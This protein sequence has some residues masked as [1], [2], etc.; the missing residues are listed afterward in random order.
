MEVDTIPERLT[1]SLT[2]GDLM[3]SPEVVDRIL[4]LTEQGWGRRRIAK[5]LGI[6]PKTVLRYRRQGGWSPFKRPIKKTRLHELLE[7]LEEALKRHKGNAEVVR[8]ELIEQHGIALSLRTIERAVRPFRQRLIAEASAT[9]RFETPPGKQLQIDFGCVKL[10]IAGSLQKVHLFIATLG[11]SRRQYLQAFSHERQSSW[12][13]GLEG[14]FRHFGGV[15]EEVL[16][17]NAKPLVILHNPITR[18]VLFNE[19]L[20]AFAS[21]WKF[22]PKACAP[23]RA[24]TKGKDERSVG[25]IKRN[26]IA[27]R[28]FASWESFE[29]HLTWWMREISDRRIHGTTGEKPLERFMNGEAMMLRP[30]EGRPPFCQTRECH[31]I[32]Q[33]DACVEVDANFYSVPWQL[34]KQSVIVQINDQEVRIFHGTDEVARHSVCLRQRERSINL[35]HLIGVVGAQR[36]SVQSTELLRPLAEYEAV[37]GGDWS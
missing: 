19:R 27:G 24:R 36:S 23:Y 37:V 26:C 7:W 9:V 14:A 18:E 11:Y 5:E 6:A 25:Y 28:E 21:Y 4:K 32:V 12:F 35:K 8:Q 29:E 31:R 34:I 22:K 15:T 20:H 16:M 3:E 17:D 13:Q 10:K 2:T 33:T 30:L 1:S